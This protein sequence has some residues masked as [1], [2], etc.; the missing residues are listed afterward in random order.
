MPF[1]PLAK[2]LFPW[3]LCAALIGPGAWA[4]KKYDPGASDT[5]VKVGQTM[6]YSGPASSYGTIGRAEAAYFKKINDEG[7]VNGRKVIF[8]SLDD[9]YSPPKTV[10]ATRRLVEQDQVLLMFGS[11]GTATNTAVQG[12]LNGRKVPQLF[13]TTGASKWNDPKNHPWTMGYQPNYHTEAQIYAKYILQAR[14]NARIGVLYQNDDYGKDYLKGVKDGLGEKSAKML[15]A[16]LSYEVTD[17][18]IDSQIQQMQ[19]MSV[20]VLIDATSPKFAA[21]AIRRVHD[22]GWKPLHILNNTSISV[23]S[24][25]TPAGLEK[26][27]GLITS[28]YGKDPTDPRWDGDPGMIEWRAFMKAYY[29]EG[30]LI[31][32]ANVF[33]YSQARTL[34][35]VLKQCGDNLTRENVM[36]QAANLKDFDT[37]TALP[38]ITINTS[39]SDFAPIKAVQMARFDGKT[40]VPFGEI[41]V[42]K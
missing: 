42:S 6:P 33:G 14:P 39:P 10:E 37:G 11:L 17:A 38:G 9:G 25:L 30:S 13:V 41:L 32:N 24:V 29:P 21:Q 8:V 12:Y 5:E 18:T 15:V 7:G 16:E 40:W 36:K 34:V 20:D 28:I 4:Q 3:A 35:Q 26:S 23:G 2:S 27:I 1:E 22:L 31:D 19:G